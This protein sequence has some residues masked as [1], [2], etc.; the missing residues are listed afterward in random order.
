VEPLIQCV[1][2]HPVCTGLTALAVGF[3]LGKIF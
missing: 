3:V 2:K 1:Q